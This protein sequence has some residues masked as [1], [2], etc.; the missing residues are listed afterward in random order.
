MVHA[1]RVVS[2]DA[3]FP[4]EVPVSAGAIILDEAGGVLILKPTYKKGWTIPG[5]IMEG[6]GETPWDA[7]RREVLEET[8]LVVSAG[9]LV[10]V[11]TRPAKPP[12]KLGLRFLFHCGVLPREQAAA[13]RLQDEEAEAFQFAP[14]ELA[15]D[16]LRGPVARRVAA[17]LTATRCL[18][19]QDGKQVPGVS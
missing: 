6:N 8:G 13:V 1:G 11:D 5:G 19:L 18:Y 10:C 16:L 17:G 9:R 15:L 7:C 4:P 2:D 14:P 12:G 3:W